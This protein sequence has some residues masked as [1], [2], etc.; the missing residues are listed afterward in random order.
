[1]DWLLYVFVC[2]IGLIEAWISVNCRP[3]FHFRSSYQAPAVPDRDELENLIDRNPQMDYDTKHR[4]REVF[5]KAEERL[6]NYKSWE[7]GFREKTEKNN[8]VF[9]LVAPAVVF[10]GLFH[11]GLSALVAL[12]YGLSYFG[13]CILLR[14]FGVMMASERD[15]PERYMRPLFDTADEYLSFWNAELKR[16][17]NSLSDRIKY[18]EPMLK[19]MD[20]YRGVSI[21]LAVGA[22]IALITDLV[23]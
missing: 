17:D 6:N 5:K 18:I 20:T 23:G 12:I 9:F 13:G 15:I 11:S 16:T 21:L 2:L 3:E 22:I 7:D 19:K 4:L 14:R 10:L 1:M 8:I